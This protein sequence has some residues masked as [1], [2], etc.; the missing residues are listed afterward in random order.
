M[1]I[2][3]LS[4]MQKVSGGEFF[5]E[6]FLHELDKEFTFH[7]ALP[8]GVFAERLR[9]KGFKIFI[10][11]EVGRLDRDQGFVNPLYLKQLINWVSETSKF[12][13]TQNTDLIVANSFGMALHASLLSFMT[14]RKFIWFHLHPIMQPGTKSGLIA[15]FLSFRSSG[16]A[17]CS[18]AVMTSLISC[19]VPASKLHV[20]YTG[21]NTNIFNETSTLAKISSPSDQAGSL[22]DLYSRLGRKIHLALICVLVPWKGHRYLI[23]A[24]NQIPQ[25]LKN[26]LC[27]EMLGGMINDSPLIIAYK[28]ELEGMITRYKLKD[29]VRFVDFKPD[30]KRYYLDID[31]LLSCSQEPEPMGNTIIEA[32]AYSKIAIVTDHGGPLELV[33][34]HVT[35]FVVNHNDPES[36]TNIIVEACTKMSV[37]ELILMQKK[38][39]ERAVSKFDIRETSRK[40]EKT[41]RDVRL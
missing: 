40:L 33:D 22:L 38:A 35:G 31:F 21:V 36:L 6:R 13:R 32:M 29:T 3:F 24:I 11:R 8:D 26:I 14:R 17:C 18:K 19:G 41:F 12:V 34:N 30:L 23:E 1:R 25:E 2:L 39:R 9:E 4:N 7:V 5:L 16:I 15:R 28:L 10:N 37:S 20:T 27:V